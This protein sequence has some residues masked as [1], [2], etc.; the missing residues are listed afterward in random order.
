MI[1]HV[2]RSALNSRPLAIPARWL[3]LGLAVAVLLR[4]SMPL[5]VGYRYD[6][7]DAAW[8]LLTADNISKHGTYS[9]D[10]GA[11]AGPTAYR[12]PLYPA[13]LGA[14]FSVFPATA[15]TAHLA[16]MVLSLV[17]ALVIT[18]VLARYEPGAA[19]IALFGMALAPA[20]AVYTAAILSEVLCATLLVTVAGVL[21]LAS[22]PWRWFVGGVF[23]GAACLCRDIYLAL[24]PTV[25]GAWFF[26]GPG[27][28]V[29]RLREG[30]LL[31]LASALVVA[32][33]TAR[34]YHHFGRIIPVSAGRLGYSLWMG[35]WATNGDFTRNDRH[36]ERVYPPEA[37]RSEDERRLVEVADR[38][39]DKGM[40][41]RTYM[42]LFREHLANEPLAVAG[43]WLVRLPKLWL[44]TRFD[45]FELHPDAFP[46]RSPAWMAIKSAL[47]GINTVVVLAALFGLVLAL[48]RR[49]A[50]AW[51]GLPLGFTL[52]VYLPLNSFENRYSQPVYLF[53]IAFAA[54]TVQEMLG[55]VKDRRRIANAQAE[56]IAEIR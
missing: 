24:V 28:R 1:R 29:R 37:F 18:G 7:G 42:Q 56:G 3:I 45:I 38:N 52:V 51:L 34:N 47:W 35:G 41:D 48:R 46:R 10:S 54:L 40:A 32:P 50:L 16:Q 23:L 49:Y 53:L 25:A 14:L 36:G 26:F 20:E 9:D 21:L 22:T 44:G 8:Y 15:T 33:W 55:W 12:P 4:L 11:L 39:P 5:W 2:L 6:T 13:F 27:E 31:M 30:A 43:T 19:P 17:S